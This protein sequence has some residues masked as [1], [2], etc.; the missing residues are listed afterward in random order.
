MTSRYTGH[1]CRAVHLSRDFAVS[2]SQRLQSACFRVVIGGT[3][4]GTTGGGTA[5]LQLLDP[6]RQDQQCIGPTA[7]RTTLASKIDEK[8]TDLIGMFWEPSPPKDAD[9]VRGCRYPVFED[10][11]ASWPP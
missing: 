7:F 8:C 9:T 3:N 4:A 2:Q 6:P 11:L 1:N 10:A 5:P